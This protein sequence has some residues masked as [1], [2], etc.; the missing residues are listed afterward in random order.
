VR[1]RKRVKGRNTGVRVRKR[2]IKKERHGRSMKDRMQARK[3]G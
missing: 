1:V 2:E 3:N